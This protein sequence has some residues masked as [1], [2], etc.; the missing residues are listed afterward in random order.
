MHWTSVRFYEIGVSIEN[1]F[2]LI[3]YFLTLNT[4]TQGLEE[5]RTNTL[6]LSLLFS[7]LNVLN[8]YSEMSNTFEDISFKMCNSEKMLNGARRFNKRSRFTVYVTDHPPPPQSYGKMF[9]GYNTQMIKKNSL[10]FQNFF[11]HVLYK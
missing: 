10:T 7:H 4:A 6:I 8:Y 9:M 5:R 2:G 3:Y 1:T 11:C